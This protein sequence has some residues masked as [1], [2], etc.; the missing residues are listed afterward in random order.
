MWVIVSI[1]PTKRDNIPF[2]I[3]GIWVRWQ[4]VVVKYMYFRVIARNH[5]ALK[6]GVLSI[7]M[8]VYE[9]NILNMA[10]TDNHIFVNFSD[11]EYKV[12]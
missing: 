6:R 12:E 11:N 1:S 4:Y 2:I 7:N 8:W 3:C 5:I 10:I 9:F